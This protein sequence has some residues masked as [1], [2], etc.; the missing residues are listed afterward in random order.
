VVDY[1]IKQ[2][3][4]NEDYNPNNDPNSQKIVDRIKEEAKINEIK[5]MDFPNTQRNLQ[6]GLDGATRAVKLAGH[7]Q[8]A[9]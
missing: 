6:C 2:N 5:N 4:N 1:Y 8:H 9:A 7:R 3:Q